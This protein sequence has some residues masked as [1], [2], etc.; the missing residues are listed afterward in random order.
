MGAMKWGIKTNEV[1][2]TKKE[3]GRSAQL[4]EGQGTDKSK[5]V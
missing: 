4:K 5:V 1:P 3:L 2:S